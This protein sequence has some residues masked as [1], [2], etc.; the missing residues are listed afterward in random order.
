M[1]EK[2]KGGKKNRK[3]GRDTKRP[4]NIMYKTSHTREKNKLK[5]ILQSNGKDAAIK[6]G[7]ECGLHEYVRKLIAAK[8]K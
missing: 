2:T 4:K 7:S 3:L 8:E 6:Y 5:R 1:A